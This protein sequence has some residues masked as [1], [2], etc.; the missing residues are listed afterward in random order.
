MLLQITQA[1][2]TQVQV[3]QEAVVLEAKTQ[4]VVTAQQTQVAVAVA[5]QRVGIQVQVMV[6]TADLGM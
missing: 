1:L 6:V 3:D 5:L 4:E 2:V